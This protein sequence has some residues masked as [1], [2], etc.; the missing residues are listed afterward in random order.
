MYSLNTYWTGPTTVLSENTLVCQLPTSTM[1]DQDLHIYVSCTGISSPSPPL[2]LPPSPSCNKLRNILSHNRTFKQ[3]QSLCK[4]LCPIGLANPHSSAFIHPLPPPPSP[5]L[6]QNTSDKILYFSFYFLDTCGFVTF[7]STS[8]VNI[9]FQGGILHNV[10]PTST[11]FL[12]IS[13]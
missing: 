7:Y 12:G 8:Y 4:V 6:S 5:S 9:N 10:A 11:C 2:L 3:T 1:G 13:F